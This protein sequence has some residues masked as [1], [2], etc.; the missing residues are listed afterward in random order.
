MSEALQV[1][2]QFSLSA[3]NPLPIHRLEALVAPENTASIHLL[4]KFGFDR[5]CLRR[6]FCLKNNRYQDVFLYA[7]LNPNSPSSSNS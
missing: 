6:D 2:I 4:E 7:L 1:M 5:E 3:Q